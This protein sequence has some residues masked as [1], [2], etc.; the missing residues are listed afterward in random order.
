MLHTSSSRLALCRNVRLLCTKVPTNVAL[1]KPSF[2]IKGIA[3]NMDN[4]LE[5]S[6]KRELPKHM[7]EK[8][9]GI[10]KLY[11]D[12]K[13]AMLSTNTLLQEKNTIQREIKSVMKAKGDIS[14]LKAKQVE[15]RLKEKELSQ[16]MSETEA[17]L[18]DAVDLVPNSIDPSV[19]AEEQIVRWINPKE[20]YKSN[21]KLA[22]N[23][24]GVELGLV[25][26]ASAATVSGSSWYYL[27][28]DGALLEQ[29]LVQY[30][31]K[32]ARKHGFKMT[33]PPSIVR[34]EVAA[35]CGFKPKD[36]NNEVQT[37]QLTNGDLC[38]TGTAE[39]PLAGLGINTTFKE[40][41]LP[42]RR[43][44]VSR[45]YRAE[46][47]ARGK[48]TKGL[49]RVHEFTKVELF[50]WATE[51]QSVDELEKLRSLQE[52]LISS[53]G[54]TA[55]VIN[56]PYNDLGSPAYKKYDIEAWMPG[57]ESFGEVTSASNCTDFQSRR[58]NTKYKS[59]VD[60][61]NYFVHT[62]NGTAMAIPRVIIGIMENFYDPATKQIAIPKVLQPYMDDKEFMCADK[63]PFS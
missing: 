7:I 57:R 28:G 31:L 25:D 1:K 41:E 2:D 45:S 29:A 39:I 10:P 51:K 35:A 27:L 3:N 47:G 33:I 54:L 38:L 52:D 59:S 9:S 50:V 24:I 15:N 37:Y 20:E 43:V 8:I 61:K 55:K 18:L 34:N 40:S 49:Y 53:L 23:K 36:L 13:T 14:S 46:A 26:L 11:E 12:H 62:L 5:V 63:N 17:A 16:A 22:H 42:I 32:V 30:A 58:L 4:I 60:G 21:E 56:M 44:G 19:T 48:D 6:K